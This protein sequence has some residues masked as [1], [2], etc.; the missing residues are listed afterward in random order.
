[1]T[2]I[3]VCMLLLLLATIICGCSMNMVSDEANTDKVFESVSETIRVINETDI[4]RDQIK[5]I[6]K[7]YETMYFEELLESATDYILGSFNGKK[8]YISA[9][10]EEI[11]EYSFIVQR[12]YRE[13]GL[14]GEIKIPV[15]H[16]DYYDLNDDIHYSSKDLPYTNGCSYYLL[17][18]RLSSVYTDDLFFFLNPTLIIP[19]FFDEDDF[20]ENYQKPMLYGSTLSTYCKSSEALEAIENNQLDVF[21]FET[22][23]NNPR[24]DGTDYIRSSDIQDVIALSSYVLKVRIEDVFF[25]GTFGDRI[26]YNCTI[27]KTIKG[28]LD[29]TTA[30]IIFLNNSVEQ[31]SSYIVAVMEVGNSNSVLA[32]SSKSSVFDCSELEHILSLIGPDS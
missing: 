31:G 32:V 3:I 2:K 8:T 15:V 13:N 1:M 28:K 29:R 5:K 10:N 11:T 6:E 18:R 25:V 17:L 30:K 20:K 27:E 26:T 9:T 14:G 12:D 19:V 23:K 21:I 22:I 16:S 24:F 7:E 4:E